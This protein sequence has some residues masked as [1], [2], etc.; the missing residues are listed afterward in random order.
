M[1]LISQL[2]KRLNELKEEYN[3]TKNPEILDIIDELQN[4]ISTL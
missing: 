1:K 3:K 2:S 4:F